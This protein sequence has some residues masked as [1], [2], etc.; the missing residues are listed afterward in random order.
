M[1]ILKY[2]GIFFA[3]V[4]L[5]VVGLRVVY[6][7]K[8]FPNTYIG[9]VEVGGL[10]QLEATEKIEQRILSF[11]E[12]GISLQIGDS[13]DWLHPINLDEQL[14][15]KT[16]INQALD[17]G[18]QGNIFIQLNEIISSPW[19]KYVVQIPLVN[20]GFEYE[21]DLIA[22]QNLYG[23]PGTDVRLQ[24]DRTVIKPLYDVSSGQILDLSTT[25]QE[26]K[27]KLQV[28]DNSPI[29][30]P[31]I[32]QKP[33]INPESAEDAVVAAER[34]LAQPLRL[35]HDW[36]V[37]TVERAEIGKWITS[38]S[39]DDRLIPVLNEVEL[40]KY[41]AE[42]GE[43][44]NNLPETADIQVDSEG[45]VISF[46]PP[47][48]GEVLEENQTIDLIRKAL[49]ERRDE[50]GRTEITEL[51][52]P[53]TVQKPRVSGTAAELGI[54]ELIGVAT[55]SFA[56][57]PNNRKF[58]I[59]NGVKFLTGILVP[60]GEEFST[61]KSLGTIDNTTGYLPELVIKGDRTIPE[62]GG[63]LCQVSTTMFRSVLDAG[64]PVTSR[65]NHSY[66]VGYYERDGNGIYIG[67][68]L[69]ATIYDPAPDFRF[70]NDTSGHILIRGKVEGDLITFELYGTKDGR[71]A[72]VDGP[73]TLTT[74]P[75]GPAIYAETEE[76][77]AGEIRRIETAHPGGTAIATY[78]VTY[79]NGRIE[80]Q[81]FNSYYRPWPERYLVGA[82][83]DPKE[84]LSDEQIKAQ[85][86]DNSET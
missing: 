65:R 82:G 38:G 7:G 29:Q 5:S 48:S 20:S 30:V 28:L 73:H 27:N 24:I 54:Q 71:V 31:I 61:I 15:Y 47:T 39:E 53:V 13:T 74:I 51:S 50:S 34:M 58:N 75:A 17:R 3:V 69:D 9:S 14:D 22:L 8:I 6:A 23:N 86:N 72:K 78:T 57:S 68:G 10:T 84:Y 77:P 11:E 18:R 41:V 67:P 70:R 1:N 16:A 25:R 56:G 26:L 64:L 60:P 79:P 33:K 4:L 35:R 40:A 83:T 46:V 59:A 12:Q 63:G 43:Q 81:E 55:T 21:G 45:K 52:L 49:E 76:L 36:R 32:L 66:R 37:Y 62:Y 42:L 44:I 19:Q 80:T 85:E 2:L